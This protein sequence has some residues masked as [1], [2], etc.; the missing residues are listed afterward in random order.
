M[1]DARP[2]AGLP[3]G[4]RSAHAA[5]AVEGPVPTPNVSRLAAEEREDGVRPVTDDAQ[6]LS[7]ADQ[8]ASE[9]DRSTADSDQ[10]ASDHDQAI[11]DRDHAASTHLSV[12]DERAYDESRNARDVASTERL[13]NQIERASTAHD[14]EM[15]GR[16]RAVLDAGPNAVIAVDSQGTVVFANSWLTTMFGFESD[17]V[18]GKPIEMLLPERARSAHVGQRAGF[19]SSPVARQVG[20]ESDVFGCRKDG[21]EF[22]VEISLSPIDTGDGPQVFATIVDITARKDVETRQLHAEKLES[23]GRLA[24]GIAHDFNNM[25]FVIQGYAELVSR[26]L[27]PQQRADLDLEDLLAS[28]QQITFAAE[29]ASGLTAGLLAFSRRQVVAPKV[30]DLNAS[31]MALHPMLRQLIGTNVDLLFKIDPIPFRIRADPGW[32]D[33]IIVNLVVNARDAMPSGGTVSISTARVDAVTARAR[34]G[35]AVAAGSYVALAVADTGVGID[36]ATR[37][38]LFEPFFTTK[39]VG[40][41]TGLG[42]AT[43][44]GIV[45]QL[46]G[47]IV[48]DSEPG[49]GATFT[50]YFPRVEAGVPEAQAKRVAQIVGA[51][52]VLVVEDEQAVRE[53]ATRLLEHLGWR[54]VAVTSAMEA[55]EAVR[56]GPPFDVLVTDVIMPNV[57]GIELA[58]QFMDQHPEIG[59][60]LMSGYVEGTFDVERLIERGARFVAKP[61][62]WERLGQAVRHAAAARHVEATR[63]P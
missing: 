33:Q 61:V 20:I 59:V 14:R 44:Y 63:L 22:P 30:L 34:L 8:T 48:V 6:T 35:P 50:L 62:T 10:L 28:V 37:D 24:G 47:H 41:G 29:R 2:K 58:E 12:A 45:K 17:E 49:N 32:I 51:G 16:F 53:L 27:A 18:L 19:A 52:R 40:K 23:V 11:S 13:E 39:G 15:T 56:T 31:V 3:G 5:A 4:S 57:S 42:L 26:G 25:L 36:E 38:H 21:S 60:V 43:A 54:V 1:T 9:S 46:G 55:F 7:E